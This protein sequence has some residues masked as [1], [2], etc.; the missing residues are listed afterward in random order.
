MNLRRFSFLVGFFSTSSA[1]TSVDM[2]REVVR[3]GRWE[4]VKAWLHVTTRDA[5]ANTEDVENFIVE[6]NQLTNLIDADIGKGSGWVL[7]L[8]A[9]N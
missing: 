9:V 6:D 1:V 3:R 7:L 2:E 8:M 5:T 4:G